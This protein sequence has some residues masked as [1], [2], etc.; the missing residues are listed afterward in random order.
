VSSST[1]TQAGRDLVLSIEVL[2]CDD[3]RRMAISVN[4]H[5]IT[6]HQCTGRWHVVLS[7]DY[8]V[9]TVAELRE[10][11]RQL[12]QARQRLWLATSTGRR[13]YQ[14]ALDRFIADV[15]PN[16]VCECRH[17]AEHHDVR[18]TEDGR[19]ER[20]CTHCPCDAFVEVSDVRE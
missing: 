1:H 2:S 12:R 3:C 9:E 8:T 6:D 5:R 16:L 11:N 20:Y 7:A 19:W 10:E 4:D 14:H 17:T 18:I 13:E 15:P